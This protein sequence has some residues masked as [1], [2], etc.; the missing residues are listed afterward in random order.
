MKNSKSV[1]IS[2]S[3]KDSYMVDKLTGMLKRM[4]ISYW[5]A[6]E[7]IPTGSSYAREIPTAI[8]N[9]EVFLLVISETAQQSIWVEK[10]LDAAVNN[11]KRIIPF[12]IDDCPLNDMFRFYLNNVQ[13]ISFL[14]DKQGSVDLL[15]DILSRELLPEADE[16]GAD[17]N[18]TSGNYA[19][20][21]I[22]EEDIWDPE[23]ERSM[24]KWKRH[25]AFRQ[26][27]A[28]ICCPYCGGP[29]ERVSMGIF[30]C[31]RCAKECYDQY[32]TVRNYIQENGPSPA[33]TIE[34]ATGVPRKTIEVFL[35]EEFLEIPKSSGIRI[36]CQT[37]GAEIRSGVMCAKCQLNEYKGFHT[38]KPKN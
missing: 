22:P 12:L 28:P 32:Q 30:R 18:I 5:K 3:S 20:S 25:N 16:R 1:F 37:C 6:P 38:K 23:I 11:R 35:K 14:E 34:H 17:S 15:R 13:M 36:R 7:M 29:I 8:K 10:E 4:G 31:M 27:K 26:N 21:V 33:I 2:Y 9:C 24:T 19:N